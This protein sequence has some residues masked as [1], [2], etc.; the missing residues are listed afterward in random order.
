M[1]TPSYLQ[2]GDCVAIIS[3][4]RKISLDEIKPAVE[5]LESWGLNVVIGKTIDAEMHQFAGSLETRLEDFQ[6]V[7]DDSTIQAIWCARGG[8]GTVQLIDLLDFTKFQQHPK[9]IIGYSDITVLH[10]HIHNFGIETLHATMPINIPTNSLAA[11]ESL[12]NALFGNQLYY[13]FSS[14]QMNIF[15][16]VNGKLVG[17][18]L[19][20]LYSLL[21]SISSIETS[22]K[23]LFI[24]DLDEYLY[25]IDRMMQNLKRNG[26]FEHLAGIIVGGFT[27][28]RD[29]E[30]KFGK[31]AEEIILEMV[32]PLNIPVVFNT[33]FGHL[34]DN[35]TLILGRNI[36]LISEEKSVKITF[37]N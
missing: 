11:K 33:P 28:M 37:D 16:N 3:T 12:K 26:Y 15:G 36:Q 18:N 21:G 17:G 9:W 24:E 8:Y 27:Q 7:L 25:H 29:N 35:R 10:S 5:L 23:I 32:K 31:T 30:I 13:E 20:V 1:K 4:A 2:K 6:T 22:K 34:D 14:H 19:S